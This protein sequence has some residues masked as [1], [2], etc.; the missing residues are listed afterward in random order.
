MSSSLGPRSDEQTDDQ[1]KA[2]RGM[3]DASSAMQQTIRDCCG[4]VHTLELLIRSARAT[5]WATIRTSNG[6][7]VGKLKSAHPLA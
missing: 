5:T 1:L 3:H 2:L 7:G 6:R 4:R